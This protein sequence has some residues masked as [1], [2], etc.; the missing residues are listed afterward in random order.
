MAEKSAT[1][2]SSQNLLK[3]LVAEM[4]ANSTPQPKRDQSY[5]GLASLT[6]IFLPSVSDSFNASI[7]SAPPSSS[8][9]NPKP[10]DLLVSLSVITLADV[11]VP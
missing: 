6:I 9:T 7:A 8:S 2:Q 11:T 4:R 1:T 3:N 10:L 5:L